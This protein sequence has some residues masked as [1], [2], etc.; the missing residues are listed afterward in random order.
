MRLKRYKDSRKM[1]LIKFYEA[2]II[3][4]CDQNHISNFLFSQSRSSKNC[5]ALKCA[6]VIADKSES[7]YNLRLLRLQFQDIKARQKLI[8]FN[9]ATSSIRTSDCTDEIT[10]EPRVNV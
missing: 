2:R 4:D 8:Y 6:L 1:K 9:D 3:V 10:L 7:K 5:P